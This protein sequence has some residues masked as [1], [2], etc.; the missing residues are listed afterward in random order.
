MD[1]AVS[2]QQMLHKQRAIGLI[3]GRTYK[4]LEELRKALAEAK[5]PRSNVSWD[6]SPHPETARNI[7]RV[8][9]RRDRLMWHMRAAH[10]RRSRGSHATVLKR[11][12]AV[13]DFFHGHE[14]VTIAL[15]RMESI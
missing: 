8:N 1:D 7:R 5:L 12:E 11:A 6:R 15:L 13:S 4:G 10:S 2:T 9:A 3:N 14:R